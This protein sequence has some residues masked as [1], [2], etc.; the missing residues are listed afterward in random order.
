MVKLEG[1][2]VLSEGVELKVS[3]SLF[4]GNTAPSA[5]AIFSDG[6]GSPYKLHNLWQH[7]FPGR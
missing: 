7:E 1:R 2:W 3:N 5:A 6:A 4:A